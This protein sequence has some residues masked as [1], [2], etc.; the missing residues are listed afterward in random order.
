M[1]NLQNRKRS[2]DVNSLAKEEADRLSDE[3]GAKVRQICD[4]ACEKAN[5]ILGIYGMKAQMQ[6]VINATEQEAPKAP[7][8][9]P[10]KKR[11]RKA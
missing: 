1:E 9:T 8:T 11:G 6:I 2:F 3:I 5:K 10:K 7:A 4:E